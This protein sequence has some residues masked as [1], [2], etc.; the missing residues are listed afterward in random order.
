M[1]KREGLRCLI[2]GAG[3]TGATIA[4][5]LAEASQA[6]VTVREAR[7]HVGGNVHDPVLPS[8]LRVH[9]H[10]PHAFHT[11]SQ[12]VFDFLSRFTAWRPYEHHVQANLDG[13]HVPV[14]C[15]YGTIRALMGQHAEAV[16]RDLRGRYRDNEHV[17]MLRLRE[18]NNPIDR[19]VGDMAYEALFYGYTVKQ[20]DQTPE[21][22]GPSVTGRVPVRMGEDNRYFLDQYQAVPQPGYTEM[23]TAMLAHEKITTHT[24]APVTA[25]D[26][27]DYDHVVYT[28]PIDMLCGYEFGPLP[29]RS[30][31]FEFDEHGADF[32]QP[33][34]QVNYTTSQ[35]YTRITEFKHMTGQ[36]HPHTA[37]AREY[38]QAHAPGVN[39]PYY[40][41]PKANEREMHARYE[42]HVSATF[43]G[44]TLAGRLADYKYY[45]MDQAVARGLSV[46][47][48][49]LKQ[50][51]DA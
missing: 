19:R 21:Q 18:S 36:A 9:A 45:N 37:T 31:R 13:L 17:P 3:L 34:A 33:V 41:I 48:S 1:L 23:V 49:L 24:S 30:L 43:P 50:W 22:L 25:Q 20:W 47:R 51:Q 26:F 32:V 12:N 4:R 7:D 39:D 28:G 46:A 11:N 27:A 38:P 10:G 15:N 40:P 42:A 5:R 29:Y 14:P 44:V 6:T 8:G 2:V 16:I 35:A